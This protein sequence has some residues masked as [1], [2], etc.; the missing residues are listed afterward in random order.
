MFV[1]QPFD[2]FLEVKYERI[3]DTSVKVTLPIKPVLYAAASF[4]RSQTL[5]CAMPFRP[6]NM[7]SRK[8]PLS[9]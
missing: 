7:A 2:E 4:L 5:R 8:L 9:M 6:T 1:P 3:S